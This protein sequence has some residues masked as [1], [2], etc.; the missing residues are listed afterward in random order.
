MSSQ[1]VKKLP[2]SHANRRFITTF[3]KA[4]QCTPPQARWIRRS[5]FT[6]SDRILYIDTLPRIL[7]S[8]YISSIY[9]NLQIFKLETFIWKCYVHELFPAVVYNQ[10]VLHFSQSPYD[11][12]LR[13]S[14]GSVLAFSNQVCGF[15]AVGFLR[16]KKFSARLPWEGK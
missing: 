9:M 12:R 3:T 15:K 1:M 7:Y 2:S 6:L 8:P 10:R 16:A 14:R 5:H 11:K 4:C 13:W